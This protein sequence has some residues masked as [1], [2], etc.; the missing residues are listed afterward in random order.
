MIE[1]TDVTKEYGQKKAVNNISFKINKGEIIGLLGPNGAGKSTTMNMLTGYIAPT[2]G[3]VTVNGY[4]MVTEPQK[5]RKSI[6]YLPE[7]PPLYMEMTVI[8][9][10]KFVY[11]IKGCTLP[12]NEHI[13]EIMKLVKIKDV[14]KRL[15][16][17]LSKGYK[18]RIGLAGAMI[19][20]P[21]I[22]I[23]DEPTV[24]LDPQQITEIRDIVKKLGK[25]RTVI[26]S[27]HILSEISEIC[28]RIII[29][30]KG[31]IIANSSISNIT[32]NI[33]QA[34]DNTVVAEFIGD[35]EQI[36]YMLKNIP[37]IE[38]IKIS[39]NGQYT[40]IITEDIREKLF[41]ECVKNN[42]TI[43][44]MYIKQLTL[45]EIFLQLTNNERNELNV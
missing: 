6:G 41:N 18:Q 17:N 14:E 42:I 21:E 26:V 27:S 7:N 25:E 3:S 8:D 44:T 12:V 28:Q 4:S 40:L 43:L 45:E 22:L 16:K 34:Q 9:Y 31:Q 30:N 15:I 38:K 33:A 23:L 37:G 5:A 10:L 13:D 2:Y 35:R 29:I 36:V 39:K 19:G 24:G 32:Q 20:N 11:D 1:F